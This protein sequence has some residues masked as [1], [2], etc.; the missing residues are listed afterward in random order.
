MESKPKITLKPKI[1]TMQEQRE[2][3]KQFMLREREKEEKRK[4]IQKQ[5]PQFLYQLLQNSGNDASQRCNLLEDLAKFREE[6]G[7]LEFL[8]WLKLKFEEALHQN[9]GINKTPSRLSFKIP[10]NFEALSGRK[11]VKN[12]LEI[13]EVEKSSKELII[14]GKSES[15]LNHNASIIQLQIE[16]LIVTSPKVDQCQICKRKFRSVLQHLRQS[17]DCKDNYSE[18]DLEDLKLALKLWKKQTDRDCYER[19][20][21][22]RKAKYE[23]KKS[24]IT[25]KNLAKKDK[26][27]RNMAKY[28]KDNVDYFRIKNSNYYAKNREAILKKKAESYKIKKK[29]K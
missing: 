7:A 25:Q 15:D 1:M 19:S 4:Q 21:A 27:A 3:Y 23:E 18:D 20:K 6:D 29:S 22:E 2:R 13:V 24:E 14:A 10:Q 9:E 16:K 26:S 17:K 8:K 12:F 28:Y 11:T 5:K